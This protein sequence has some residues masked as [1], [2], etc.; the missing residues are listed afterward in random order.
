[1]CQR[2]NERSK[3]LRNR[4]PGLIVEKLHKYSQDSEQCSLLSKTCN[5][6]Q[7][8]AGIHKNY[9]M[10]TLFLLCILAALQGFQ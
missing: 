8:Q 1:V 4:K 2:K 3:L 10:L 9:T 5:G 7:K 6:S